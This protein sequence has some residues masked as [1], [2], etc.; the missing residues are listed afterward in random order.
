M[1]GKKAPLALSG[2]QLAHAPAETPH[3]GAYIQNKLQQEQ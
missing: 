3:K 2:P 1:G